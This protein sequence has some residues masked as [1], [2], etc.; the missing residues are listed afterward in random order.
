[1]CA[2]LFVCLFCHNTGVFFWLLTF[3]ISIC[4]QMKNK[5]KK[6]RKKRHMVFAIF[7]SK[8]FSGAHFRPKRLKKPYPLGRTYLYS[9]YKGVPPPLPPPALPGRLQGLLRSGGAS[10]ERGILASGHLNAPQFILLLRYNT[11]SPFFLEMATVHRPST[12]LAF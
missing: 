10:A 5:I 9:P 12:Y 2:L 6:E 8:R 7:R 4:M 1:M 3:Y 11:Q